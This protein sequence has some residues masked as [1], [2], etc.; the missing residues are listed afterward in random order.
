MK[1][2]KIEANGIRLA[3][4]DYGPKGL[5][6]LILIR[7][8]G[9]QMVHWPRELIEGFVS[10]GFRTI[11]FDNRDVGLSQRFAV[12]N[13]PGDADEI[14]NL[15]RKGEPIPAPY[16]LEDQARDVIGLM[17]ALGLERAHIVG[18]SMGGMISQQIMLLAPERLFSAI[19][20]MSS[21][22][23]ILEQTPENQAA[24]IE[25][26]QKLLVRPQSREEYLKAQVEEHAKWGSP[27]YPMCEADI[28]AVADVAYDRGIDAEGVNRQLL[29]LLN[30]P[31]LRPRLAKS[32]LPCLI[33]H[34]ENDALVPLALGREIAEVVPD[35]EFRPVS[36]MGHI[37]TP[38][39]APLMVEAVT[40][41]VSRRSS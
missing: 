32:E 4:E 41:F 26:S 8:Q 7:G 11:I 5:T 2:E 9:S 31:D 36:G 28:R 24:L 3:F 25:I 10:A 22:R 33:I 17:D 20:V 40:D 12:A 30:A 14:L 35:S 1:I 18:I 34:G 21:C 38:A 37:I 39:L 16:G 15:L 27:G 19:I 6:P 29:A 13:V 23:P